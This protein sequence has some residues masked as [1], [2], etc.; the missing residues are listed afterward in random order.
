MNREEIKAMY[1]MRDIL[2]KCGL[3]QPNHA[4]FIKCPFHK[5][6]HTASMKIYDKDFHC[7]GCNANGDIFTFIQKFYDI[8][9]NTASKLN[10][11]PKHKG[12][13]TADSLAVRVWAGTEHEKLKKKPYIKKGTRVEI[14]DTIKD[15]E[16][17]PWYYI[18]I[19]SLRYGHIY[20]FSSAK[21]IK[22]VKKSQ[23][24][25]L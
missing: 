19:R 21:F 20:G 14:C 22:Q 9:F 24:R 13:V 3:P 18:R 7:F 17:N 15:A 4:G 23:K 2:S 25:T 12:I 10:K 5:G 11:T 8:S 6:D 1:S 16:G